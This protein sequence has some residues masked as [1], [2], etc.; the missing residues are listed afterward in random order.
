MSMGPGGI[1]SRILAECIAF[2]GLAAIFIL[3]VAYIGYSSEVMAANWKR[4]F[5]SLIFLLFAA[6]V[7]VTTSIL[8][9]ELPRNLYSFLARAGYR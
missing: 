9:P 5:A 4:L 8:F 2:T 1:G 6:S 7:A 3:M